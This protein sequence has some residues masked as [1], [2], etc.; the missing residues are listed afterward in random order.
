MFSDKV[1]ARTLTGSIFDRLPSLVGNKLLVREHVEEYEH[2]EDNYHGYRA[3]HSP[4]TFQVLYLYDFDQGRCKALRQLSPHPE[5]QDLEA[6][7]KER[8]PDAR[9]TVMAR[10][11]Y[12]S[13]EE[14]DDRESD[15]SPEWK[16]HMRELFEIEQARQQGEAK[17]PTLEFDDP[18]TGHDNPRML[19]TR[20]MIC[21]PKIRDGEALAMTT[22]AIVE[23][24]THEA[25]GYVHYFGPE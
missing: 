1:N 24:P 13:I 23:L 3:P 17:F 25:D 18:P 2:D 6:R 10:M 19:F 7:L 9:V 11:Y 15:Q 12:T 21:L 16:A 8:N 14:E 20:S 5:R 4:W 22:S